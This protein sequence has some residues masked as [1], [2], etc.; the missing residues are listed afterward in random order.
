M[1]TSNQHGNSL[2]LASH[3]PNKLKEFHQ[4]VRGMNIQIISL[5]ELQFVDEIIEDGAT[6]E[7]NAMIKAS[8]IYNRFKKPVIGED[9]GLEVYALNMKPGVHTAIFGGPHKNAS[10][11][12]AQLLH[13]L[14][15]IVDRRARFKTCIAYMDKNKAWTV[16]GIIEG[17]IAVQPKGDGGFGYDPVFI[18]EGYNS[19]FAELPIEVKNSM[20]HRGRALRNC[21]ARLEQMFNL[22]KQVDD[23]K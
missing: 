10:D 15:G 22:P 8:T 20:S 19:T 23:D 12:I 14:S 11:N 2:I 1:S 9:T 5:A 16:E 3:N 21:L 7:A 6:I 17:R 18:P 13:Q 4:L